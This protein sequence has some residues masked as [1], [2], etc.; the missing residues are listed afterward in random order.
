[1]TAAQKRRPS[2]EALVETQDLGLELLHPGGLEITQE[3]AH[4]CQVGKNTSVLDVASG[5]GESACYLAERL[6]ANVVGIDISDPMIKRARKKA[7]QRNLE[8]E[9][10]KGDAHRLP[11]GTNVFDVVISECTTCILDKE[12]A[13]REMARVVKPNGHVGIHD[14]CWQADAP[15]HMRKQLAEIEGE[16]PETLEGWKVL[17]ERAGLTEVRTLDRSSLIPAWLKEIRKKLGFRGQ[18]RIFLRVTRTWGIRGLKDVRASERIFRSKYA[19]Y[20]IVVG[21]K[22]A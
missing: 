21:R 14:M 2:L 19:G 9:F 1:V 10:R 4:L 12:K 13:I 15:E 20:G 5:T 16:S 7:E 8:I 17:F 11:F 18:L 6:G 22:P 3:L